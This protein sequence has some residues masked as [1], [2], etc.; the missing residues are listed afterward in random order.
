M[1]TFEFGSCFHNPRI[2][3]AHRIDTLFFFG[4]FTVWQ[5]CSSGICKEDSLKDLCK[6]ECMGRWQAWIFLM[7]CFSWSSSCCCCCCWK[8]PQQSQQQG[9]KHTY[10][11]SPANQK[12]NNQPFLKFVFQLRNVI[13]LVDHSQGFTKG[14]IL[15][16][17]TAFSTSDLESSLQLPDFSPEGTDDWNVSWVCSEI[18]HFC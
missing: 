7:F 16:R 5:S 18:R 15:N 10:K 17:P 3:R 12:Q 14:V 1:S 8:Q 6:L 9:K 4:R 13:F 11:K 2:K